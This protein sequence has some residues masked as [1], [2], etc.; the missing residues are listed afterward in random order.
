MELLS[1]DQVEAIHET[2]MT[3]LEELGLRVL[4]DEGRRLFRA[5]GADVNEADQRVRF[6]RDLGL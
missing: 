5:A 2:S 3:I 1:A 6:D 4:H